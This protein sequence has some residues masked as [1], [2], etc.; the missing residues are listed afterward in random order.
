MFSIAG[1]WRKG[2]EAGAELFH[3]SY[4]SNRELEYT[5]A[6]LLNVLEM[7]ISQLTAA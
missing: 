3:Q 5:L 4:R 7:T 6:S 2:H 1:P